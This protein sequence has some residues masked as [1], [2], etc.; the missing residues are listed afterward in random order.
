MEK[1]FNILGELRKN[2]FWDVNFEKLDP[3]LS[4][5]LIIE[6]VFTLGEA[7]E[8][9]MI[10][11]YYGEE[12]IIDVLK[13]L[14]YLDPKTLNFASKFFNLPLQS[15]KCYKRKQLIPQYWD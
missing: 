14:N 13:N 2:Y 15:F 12:V 6:R 8:I 10:I 9:M 11:N 5:R 7:G 4:K 1:R 3:E